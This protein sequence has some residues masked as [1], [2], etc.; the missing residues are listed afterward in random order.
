MYGGRQAKQKKLEKNHAYMIDERSDL[1]EEGV[2]KCASA[3]SWVTHKQ[4]RRERKDIES[5]EETEV[6]CGRRREK[7]SQKARQGLFSKDL[8]EVS[9]SQVRVVTS[10]I[11]SAVLQL[12]SPPSAPVRYQRGAMQKAKGTLLLKE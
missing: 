10:L 12:P 11:E 4:K 5:R 2:N 9:H 3:F 6:K 1:S 8:A 7:K